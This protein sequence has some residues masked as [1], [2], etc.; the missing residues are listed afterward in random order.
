MIYTF[1][2]RKKSFFRDAK[3]HYDSNRMSVKSS[4]QR[5][6]VQAFLLT[7]R[8][9]RVNIEVIRIASVTYCKIKV[10]LVLT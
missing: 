6:Y 8:T 10:L 9:Y 1:E 4:S 7:L 5:D 3:R 2:L